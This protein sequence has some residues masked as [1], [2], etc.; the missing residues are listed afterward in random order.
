MALKHAFFIWFFILSH[1]GK[2]QL[3][4][5]RFVAL[6]NG[7]YVNTVPSADVLQL[8][9]YISDIVFENEQGELFLPTRNVR[10]IDFEDSLLTKVETNC[11]KNFLPKRMSFNV[12]LDSTINVSGAFGGDLDPMLGMY[13][14][15]QSGY[16]HFKL[17]TSTS[18]WHIGGYSAP[19]NTSQRVHLEVNATTKEIVCNIDRMIQGLDGLDKKVIMSPGVDAVKASLLFPH[20]FEIKK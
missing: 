15:W 8:K 5:I 12:G 7:K 14:A 4:M 3:E 1:S 11:P 9:F 13:W 16:I 20:I 17:E 18:K 6:I 19:Y 2:S 10:L